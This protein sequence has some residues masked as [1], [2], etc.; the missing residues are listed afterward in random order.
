MRWLNVPRELVLN[1]DTAHDGNN[2]PARQNEPKAKCFHLCAASK[3]GAEVPKHSF[4]ALAIP[5][6]D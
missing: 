1:R 2:P 4:W 6:D 5:A 3:P